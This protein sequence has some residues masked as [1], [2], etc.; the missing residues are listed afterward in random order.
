MSLAIVIYFGIGVVTIVICNEFG[1]GVRLREG[2]EIG[3][4]RD[5]FTP[6]ALTKTALIC[7]AVL[8]PIWLLAVMICVINGERPW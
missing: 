3:F 4:K 7:F 6:E 5:P 8:W 1:L 2:F